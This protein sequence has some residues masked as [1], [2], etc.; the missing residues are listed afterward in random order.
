M[1]TQLLK[2]NTIE[3]ELPI[4]KVIYNSIILLPHESIGAWN[5]LDQKIRLLDKRLILG[6]SCALLCNIKRLG[7]GIIHY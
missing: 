7:L 2:F 1:P 3:I 6:Y 5:Y 4:I